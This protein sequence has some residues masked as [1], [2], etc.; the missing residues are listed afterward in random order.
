[1]QNDE[2]KIIRRKLLKYIIPSVTAM[3]VYTIYTMVDGMF[4]SNGVGPNALAAVNLC[5]PTASCHLE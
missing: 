5:M 2:K 1:M 3:W 4:V